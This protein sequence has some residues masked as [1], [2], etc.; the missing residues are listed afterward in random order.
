MVFKQKDVTNSEISPVLFMD[1]DGQPMNFF[2]CPGPVKRKLQP[3]IVAGGGVLCSVQQP[4]SILLIDPA[5]GSSIP[6]NATHWYVSTQYILDCIKNNEQLDVESYRLN[7]VTAPGSSAALNTK[8]RAHG[9]RL[10]YTAEEDA[11]ILSYV[12]KHKMDAG[13]NRIWQ[14]MEKE[15]LT[16]HSWQSMKCRYKVCLAKK[17][18]E[19]LEMATTETQVPAPSA[20]DMQVEMPICTEEK[21]AAVDS[22]AEQP[23]SNPED[24]LEAETSDCQQH[25]PAPS[26][27]AEPER[28][29]S[30]QKEP[31]PE[32]SSPAQPD[33]FTQK[34]KKLTSSPGSVTP[35]RRSPRRPLQLD[36]SPS[37]KQYSR[38]L[39]SSIN[40]EE[41]S[42]RT[43][44]AAQIDLQ[45]DRGVE[46]PP[47]KKARGKRISESPNK[48]FRAASAP[49]TEP[50]PQKAKSKQ[51]RNLGI[52][53]MATKEFEDSSDSDEEAA[54]NP[55]KT[56]M[57]DPT[58]TEPPLITEDT[59]ASPQ[60]TSEPET[61]PQ[62]SLQETQ[63]P[64]NA[65]QPPGGTVE[66]VDAMS[67][68]HL[69]IFDTE[70]QEE[71]GS[72]ASSGDRLAPAGSN[73]QPPVKTISNVSPTQAQLEDDKQRLTE[74]MCETKQDLVSVTK[75][76]LKT[77]GDF[78]EAR[79]LLLN[80]LSS[81]PRWHCC[82][83]DLLVSGDAAIREQLRDKY[84]EE[85]VAKRIVFLELKV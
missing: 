6:E 17:Q 66:A 71:G 28:A 78:S 60:S 22:K 32:E 56:D 84:G 54:D 74:L 1:V 45:K 47:S 8:H 5:A 13:G 38:N 73:L 31:V 36:K 19:G 80:P 29:V 52:L 49:E 34:K 40:G 7:P 48:A 46:Q 63:A 11:A 24:T 77:S 9:G 69:F 39:R 58:E 23:V 25:E 16:S 50:A 53:E 21:I 64:S 3:L 44:S 41:R 82:D 12:S 15:R 30:P 75:A 37:P 72:Q 33:S 51:K 70:T 79:L 20:E 83:D 57:K 85:V 76:L 27:T 61:G 81:R 62:E 2:L 14:E 59:A 4:G 65:C 26:E 42:K 67:R 35:Q 55:A 18:S 68:A 10:S 43:K